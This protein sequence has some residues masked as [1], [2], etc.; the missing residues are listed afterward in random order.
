ME[1]QRRRFEKEKDD[2]FDY[3]GFIFAKE[4]L[5]IIDNL[6]RSKQFLENY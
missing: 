3:G 4:A 6:E 1:N 5:N 2:A